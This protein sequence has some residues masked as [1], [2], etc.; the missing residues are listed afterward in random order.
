M[1]VSRFQF[2]IISCVALL[3]SGD[4]FAYVDPGSG[5]LLWQGFIAVIGAIIFYIRKPIRAL[6]AIMKKVLGKTIETKK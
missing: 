2:A 4:A 1:P 5:I 3:W 6:R